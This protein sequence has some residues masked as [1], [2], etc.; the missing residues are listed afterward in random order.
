MAFEKYNR[1]SYSRCKP[2][3]IILDVIYETYNKFCLYLISSGENS[4]INKKKLNEFS[5]STIARH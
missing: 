4:E 1:R 2:Y 3:T 5:L